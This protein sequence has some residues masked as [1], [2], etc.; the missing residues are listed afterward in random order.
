MKSAGMALY[1]FILVNMEQ[2]KTDKQLIRHEKI[3]LRQ[4]E[5]LLIIPFY[6]LYI[7]NYLFNLLRYKDCE[8]AYMNIFFEKEAY[9]N[10]DDE[11]Y[12][13]KRKFWA[14]ARSM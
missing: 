10:E 3:H 2:H 13:I 7:I 5:E 14:W 8:K 12:L 9:N 1:P 6:M 11:N 4:Q